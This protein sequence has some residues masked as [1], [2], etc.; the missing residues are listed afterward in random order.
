MKTTLEPMMKRLLASFACLGILSTQAI[1]TPVYHPP[2]TNL[3]F[4]S[5]SNGRTIMSDIANP[6]ASAASMMETDD[7]VRFGVFS[8]IGGG[9]EYGDVNRLFDEL[10]AAANDLQNGFTNLLPAAVDTSITNINDI[11]G[12]IEDNGYG[13][14]FVSAHA[15]LMPLVVSADWL[16]GSMVFD[17]NASGLVRVGAVHD[18]IVFNT[19]EAANLIATNSSGLAGEVFVNATNPSNITYDLNND[20]SVILNAAYTVETAVGYSRPVLAIGDTQ[21]FAG[22][23]AKL[24]KVTLYRDFERVDTTSD[25]QEL[26]NDLDFNDGKTTTGMGLDAGVLWTGNH[27]RLGATVTNINEPEFKYNDVDPVKLATL[28]NDARIAALFSNDRTYT[29]KRQLTFEG[30]LHSQNQNWLISGSFDANAVEGPAGDEYQWMTASVAYL[31][32]GWLLPGVR[33]GYRVN[34]AGTKLSYLTGGVT[35]FKV[36]N[37]DLAYGLEEVEVD[38]DK[39]PRSIMFN[40]GLEL[41]F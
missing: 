30:A 1:A 34:Q 22:L 14:A 31:N 7:T 18:E 13:K 6:A 29:M 32:D 33:A 41:T 27:Y 25:S 2:G 3:T 40:V 38:G 11:L 15:P 4:G 9:A 39:V 36:V 8:S 5:V 12:A 37:M 24:Y 35:L 10:D 20:S 16:G 28:T 19:T 21:L 26:F 17:L 23:R